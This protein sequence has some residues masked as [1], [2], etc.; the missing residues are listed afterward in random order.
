MAASLSS[1]MD[2]LVAEAA[3]YKVVTKAL[4][5][6]NTGKIKTG[7]VRTWRPV[8][9]YNRLMGGNSSNILVVDTREAGFSDGH[10][11]GAVNVPPPFG[12]L[13]NQEWSLD[14]VVGSMEDEDVR[15]RLVARPGL[16][17]LVLCGPAEP[18]E[19]AEDEGGAYAWAKK[20]AATVQSQGRVALVA[21]LPQGADAVLQHY[22]FLKETGG[23]GDDDD[24]EV[25]TTDEEEEEADSSSRRGSKPGDPVDKRTAQRREH[26]KSVLQKYPSEILDSF[27]YLGNVK[28]V[29]NAKYVKEL[30]IT[31]VVDAS[32]R[33]SI[34]EEEQGT[35]VQRLM[36]QEN[37]T[38]ESNLGSHFPKLIRFIRDACGPDGLPST[39]LPYAAADEA[40][41]TATPDPDG[42]PTRILIF[43]AKG[44]SRSATLSIFATMVCSGLN[45]ATSAALVTGRR[46]QSSPNHGFRLQLMDAE[47]NLHGKSSVRAGGS[48]EP[49]SGGCTIS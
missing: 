24:D 42:R 31:H 44:V 27:L 19:G 13:A 10:V 16:V 1:V 4:R 33:P 20:L 29:T 28:H 32:N 15:S 18:T 5:K 36:V 3:E 8:Q 9:L 26:L 41:S 37:D 2:A 17:E 47:V 7:A 6:S 25:V 49:K 34:S 38:E 30:N 35:S 12:P 46:D 39:M 40:E 43:C 21:L 11:V 23:G 14:M 45:L 22:P 48:L